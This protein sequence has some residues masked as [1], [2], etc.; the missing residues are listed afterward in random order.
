MGV[1]AIAVHGL[2][3]VESMT[4]S[5]PPDTTT[6]HRIFITGASGCIG[7]YITEALIQATHHELFLLVRDPAKLKLDLEARP[8]I[9]V[10]PGDLY[11]IE[12]HRD[13]LG[14]ID[15]AILIATAWGGEQR[16]YDINVTKTLQLMEL[17]DAQRCQQVI[18]FSTASILGRDNQPLPQAGQVGT[19][20]IRS[21][22]IC[23][24][25]IPQLAIAPKVTTLFPTLVFGGDG[26]K[27]YSQ[28]SAGLPEV[29]KWMKVIRFLSAD[30][31]F[32]ITHAQDIAQVVAHLV[33]HPPPPGE[34]REWVLGNDPLTANQAIAQICRYLNQ[35][36]Y[37]R[38]PLSIQLA[39]L[40]IRVFRIQMEAWDRFCLNYRH[41]VYQRPMNPSRIGRPHSCTSIDDLLAISG[42][43]RDRASS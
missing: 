9:H 5:A 18:Y 15:T 8:G 12:D 35:R 14:T 29:L 27:P 3:F 19:G 30:G 7:H 24:Q 21:K 37:F 13:L 2:F 11:D 40:L 38:I 23:H 39:N 4:A 36:I 17:L 43:P 31:S 16:A 20:Y 10:I 34:P 1:D 25:R 41:F 42:I 22:Y 6:P 32:H 26:Q 33:D 28:I